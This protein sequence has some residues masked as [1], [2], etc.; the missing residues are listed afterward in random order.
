MPDMSKL[1][2]NGTVYDVRDPT[3][4]PAGYGLG[5]YSVNLPL[6]A[7]ADVCHVNGWYK[8][9]SDTIMG[10]GAS[11]V[12]RVDSFDENNLVQTAYSGYYSGAGTVIQRRVKFQGTWSE[13]E[14]VNPHMVPGVEYRTTERYN[15]KAVYAK[16]VLF[17]TL[18]ENTF[19]SV[20]VTD[21][22]T[23]LVRVEGYCQH[24]DGDMIQIEC[25][26]LISSVKIVGGTNL[27]IDAGVNASYWSCNPIVY[28][29]KE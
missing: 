22:I 21:G 14:W 20:W 27:R 19:K 15:G 4:A 28:Y 16:A 17:Y 5:A 3:K 8:I 18:P 2:I 29:T 11:A 13:W 26:S 6:V 1:E 25:N 12:L 10:I 23:A 24:T 9:N 7:D